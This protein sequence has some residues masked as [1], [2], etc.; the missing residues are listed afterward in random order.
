MGLVS[1][2]LRGIGLSYAI[3]S[4]RAKGITTPQ[5]LSRL[6][7]ADYDSLGVKEVGDRK[8]L[9]YL[10]QRIRMAVKGENGVNG[11]AAIDQGPAATA[12]LSSSSPSPDDGVSPEADD[13]DSLED[14]VHPADVR[15]EVHDDDFIDNN[16]DEDIVNINEGDNDG[17]YDEAPGCTTSVPF[18]KN[19]SSGDASASPAKKKKKKKVS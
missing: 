9:F 14:I 8:K 7:L 15:D 18:D 16:N 11:D 13:H 6:T 12:A 1:T 5:K 2:W 10:V 17:H 19:R 4:F 3:S